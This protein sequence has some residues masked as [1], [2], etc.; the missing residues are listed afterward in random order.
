MASS[1]SKEIRKQ[2]EDRRPAPWIQRPSYP[3]AF[4]AL[5]ISDASALVPF[6]YIRL[7]YAITIGWL[8]SNEWPDAWSILGMALIVGSAIYIAHRELVRA[9]EARAG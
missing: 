9:R 1:C 3:H 2:E 5:R 8:L 4:H 7:I 6:G